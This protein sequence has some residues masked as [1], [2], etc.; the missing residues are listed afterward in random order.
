MRRVTDVGCIAGALLVLASPAR[1]EQDPLER[2]AL[3][4]PRAAR[5]VLLA[6]TRAD[7]RLVAV[8]ERG[9]ILLSDDNGSTWH[10]ANV[11][12]SVSLTN[13]YFASPRKGWAVGHSGIVLYTQDGGESWVKQLDGRQAA[14]LELEAAK[15]STKPDDAHAQRRLAEAQRLVE[16]G[17]DKPFLDVYFADEN[18]GLIV[19]AYGLIFSTE[20]GGGSWRP[21]TDRIDNPKGKHLYSICVTGRDL[22]IAGEQ[23]ALFRSFDG[24]QTFVE[25]KTPYSGTYFGVVAATG[26]ELVVY[27]LRGN[28][29][30]SRNAGHNWQ[31]I[32]IGRSVTLSA[33]LV[34]DD[35]SVV[36]VNQDGDVF[37]SGD[38]GRT[39]RAVPIKQ[40][41]PFTGVAQAADGNL[42]LSGTRGVMRLEISTKLSK[43]KP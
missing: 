18:K 34:L 19:G 35:G 42:I 31:E 39:F 9:V 33:G 7:K 29:Y 12:V 13:V 6:V 20:D 25:V 5:S 22:Y 21:L 27:G 10:Q 14:R 28:A 30:W 23:G 4:S 43:A 37:K 40:G 1:A 17:P 38:R 16:D 15:A 2:P 3:H 41:F 26:G 32:E 24:E 36:L 11:S 8:G